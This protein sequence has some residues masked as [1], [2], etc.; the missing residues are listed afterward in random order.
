MPQVNTNPKAP[1]MSK[2]AAAADA[3]IPYRPVQEA[4]EYVNTELTA[5]TP[6]GVCI[7]CTM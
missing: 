2:A 4:V 6:A 5:D 7:A 1:P 3:D